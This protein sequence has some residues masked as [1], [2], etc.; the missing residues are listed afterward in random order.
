MLAVSSGSSGSPTIWPRTVFDELPV[1]LRFEQVFRGSFR[2][3]ERR[4]LAV[5]CFPLGSW[6]GGIY[7]TSCCRHLAAK[8]YPIT[9]VAPGNNVAEI[10]RVVR[11]IGAMFDQVGS[12]TRP[13]S[14]ACSTSARPTVWTGPACMSDWC[15]PGRCSASSGAI[16]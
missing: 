8:G 16:W 12:G 5:V 6:V 4:T 11:E 13:S 10:L 1:A 14:R 3:D 2:A 9:V 7:T 15:S